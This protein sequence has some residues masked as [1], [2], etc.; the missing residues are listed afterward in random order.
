MNNTS[1]QKNLVDGTVA[2][3]SSKAR[4]GVSD[5]DTIKHQT[6]L[7]SKDSSPIKKSHIES[8]FEESPVRL[9]QQ[10]I[11]QNEYELA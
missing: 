6:M 2:S 11:N 3:H 4:C 7:T 8:V 9:P 5:I 10:E 1:S